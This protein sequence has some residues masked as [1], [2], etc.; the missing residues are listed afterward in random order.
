MST[1]KLK[2]KSLKSYN[3]GSKLFVEEFYDSSLHCFYY[4]VYQLVLHLIYKEPLKY[5]F[6]D[7]DDA[8]NYKVHLGNIELV[9]D[10]FFG[11]C[12]EGQEFSEKASKL[13]ILRKHADY[14]RYYTY[15]KKKTEKMKLNC[16]TIRNLISEKENE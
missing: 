16:E 10:N 1:C 5:G 2:D 12:V 8:K 15:E 4:S 13:F 6:I 14:N 11:L 7:I 3:A 9:R